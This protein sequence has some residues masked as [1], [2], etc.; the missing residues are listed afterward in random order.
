MVKVQNWD[1]PRERQTHGNVGTQSHGSS[2]I[3]IAE[4]PTGV[5]SESPEGSPGCRRKQIGS[6]AF[7]IVRS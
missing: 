5:I 7:F 1:H 6:P 2:W 4:L 3:R